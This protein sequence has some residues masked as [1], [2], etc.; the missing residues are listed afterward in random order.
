MKYSL[1]FDSEKIPRERFD[2][3]IFGSGLAGVTAAFYAAKSNKNKSVAVISPNS[4]ESNSGLAQGGIA[5]SFSETDSPIKHYKD[6]LK[7]G[8][9]IVGKKTAKIFSQEIRKRIDELIE[10][11]LNF[12]L[13]EEGKIDLGLEGGHSENRILHINGDDTGKGVTEFMTM[14]AND[15][16]VNFLNGFL[17]EILLEGERVGGLVLS[18]QEEKIY[19]GN[20]I[21]LATGGFSSLF[22]KTTNPPGTKGGGLAAAL[23]AGL[24]IADVE[25]EQFHPTSLPSRIGRNFLISES[26]RGEGAILLNDK[27]QRFMKKIKGKE[28]ATRDI[29]S[30]KIFEEMNAGNKVF[31]DCRNL[32]SE[33]FRK[34]FPTISKEFET[35]NINIEQDLVPVEPAAHYSVGGITANHFGKT[36]ISGIYA[37]GE[38]SC[39]GLHGGNRLASNSLAEA[40]S[41]GALCGEKIAKEKHR[42]GRFSAKSAKNKKN[43]P[44]SGTIP[45]IKNILWEKCGIIRTE[46]G[47]NSALGWIK[48]NESIF[49]KAHS[50]EE[51]EMINSL[52]LAE[53]IV[54]QCIRREESRGSHYR[55]DFPKKD[56]KFRR[57]YYFKQAME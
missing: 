16:G 46:T 14:L 44:E 2:T 43:K 27:M 55:E 15:E 18:E 28:L 13:N 41:F 11:G 12:D 39:T 33:K 9:G 38:V 21:V 6:T 26:V 36:N 22:S 32:D 24:E 45:K 25:F 51:L 50:I 34:R 42:G 37:I 52:T 48:E 49:K 29:V 30:R 1:T 47:L 23:R 54:K 31:L 56:K 7:S 57:H 53:L 35:Q 17:A 4:S 19:S 5:C 10:L 8:N 3:I 40:I 20:A